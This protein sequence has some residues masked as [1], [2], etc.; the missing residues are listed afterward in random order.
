MKKTYLLLLLFVAFFAKAQNDQKKQI[1]LTSHNKESVR[2]FGVVRCLSTEADSL[3]RIQNPSRG[4]INE[5][6]DW[7]APKIEQYKR[8]VANGT[9]NRATI[10]TI[11]V[12]VHVIHN[13]D[14]VGTGENINDNQV[15]SQIRVLNEDFRRMLGTPGYN[16]NP[17]G[18][19]IEIEFCMAQTDPFGAA[20][21]GINRVNTGVA[22]YN[23]MAATDAMKTTTIWDPTQYLNMW[24][25]RFGGAMAGTLGYAQFPANSVLG[26][27]TASGGAANTDGVVSSFD[28]FGSQAYAAGTYNPTYNLGRTMT[29]EVGH[30]VGL[31]HIWGD[32]NC[33]VDDF[34]ADTPGSDAPNFGCPN[35]NSCVDPAPDPRDMVENYMDY[36]DDACMNI[37]TE[38]Q[39][40]R[41]RTVFTVSPRR[42]ELASST[43]CQPPSPI[44]GFNTDE[45]IINEATDCGYQD[46]VLSLGIALAPSADATVTFTTSGTATGSG[47]DF[48]IFPASVIFPAGSTPTRN[49]TVRIYNDGQ[50][51]STENIL[52]GMNIATSGNAVITSGTLKD[53]L[54]TINDDDFA[55]SPSVTVDIMNADFNTGANGFT[56]TGNAGSDFFRLG[57]AVTASSAF[58]TIQ[59]TNATQ[60]AF[61]NDDTC[62]CNKNNDMLIS[63]VF[64]LA[65]L[66]N[67]TLTFDHAFSA[68]VLAEVG[69]VRIST[70]GGATW[71]TIQT[72]TNTSTALGGGAISTPWVNGNTINLAAY[73]G[74]TNLRLA[75][76]YRDGGGWNY[77]MAIDN[78]RV[79]SSTVAVIQEAVNSANK[80]NVQLRNNETVHWFDPA[81]NNVMG[82][83][84][85]ASTFD[86]GCTTVEVDRSQVSLGAAT[87]PFIDTNVANE[88]LAKTF[89]I[90]PTN[91]SSTGNYTV[92]FYYTNAE[93]L[94]WETATGKSR[95]ELHVI[96]VI[97]NPVNLV[98]DI[99][100]SG[101][102]IEEIPATIVAF[103]SDVIF[104]ATF[105]TNLA[106]G[107]ALGPKSTIN[108]GDIVSTWNGSTWSNGS[109][110]KQIAIVINGDYDTALNGSFECCSLVVNSGF[111]F[112]IQ[113][114][115]YV[116]VVNELTNN[117]T[118]SIF[119]NGSLIQENDLAINTGTISYERIASVRLQDY[120]YWSSPIS[121]FDV[122][123]ISPLT[124]SAFYWTWNSTALNSNSGQ[125]N[126]VNASSIMDPGV[127]YIVRAP[128]GFSNTVNQN[129]VVNFNNGVP[130]NG[131][132]SPVISRGDNLNSGAVSSSGI[133]LTD[134][135]D[136]WNLIGNPYPSSI[137]VNA[138]LNANSEIDGFVRVWSHSTLPTALN[139]SSFYNNF[140]SNYSASD[141]ITINGAGSTSGPGTLS[142]IGGGQSFFVLMNS[143]S[144]ANSTVTFNN[145]MRDKT[146]SN[147]QFYRTSNIENDFENHRIWLDLVSTTETSRTL[148]SYNDRAT[149]GRDRLYDALTNYRNN[150]NIYSLLEN[151]PMV[152]QGKALPFSEED[153]VKIGVKVPS[154]GQYSI[155]I[156]ALDGLFANQNIF[157]KDNVNNVVHDLK[158]SPYSFTAVAGILNNR[159]EI[160]YK[161][162]VLSAED[163]TS[164][165]LTIYV[166]SKII[167]VVS[168]TEDIEEINVFDVLGR[169]LYE[170][171]SINNKTFSIPL[172]NT[173]NQ[174][175]I[176]KVKFKNGQ[177]YTQKIIL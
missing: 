70:N 126:W 130:N 117:G 118:F 167:N 19:D 150:Q 26:G 120:V 10:L 96:K 153:V 109:P 13:G 160:I 24:S 163:F 139:S 165:N 177:V 140:N 173:N 151:N 111:N 52:I 116:L 51:E 90:N 7:L 27:L 32:G 138:F 49:V 53:H 47:L 74:Q 59:N 66:S 80:D 22:S 30:W 135:D 93:V 20:T 146:F 142:V 44:I 127:G 58:W 62:N 141:Y 46:V 105:S 152:I 100:F 78:V 76:R 64:S 134:T 121:G 4:T 42:M 169:K 149:N 108:C 34:C 99:N 38:D 175:L 159:F 83:I 69:E 162:T 157:I 61:S 132:Y 115:N 143:G 9:L 75:F 91:D 23:S 5:F 79:F 35:T 55:P 128:N 102:N 65:G 8:Q 104:Q 54:I 148:I 28:A 101:F 133:T 88:I 31:R 41:I 84:Q 3:S 40:S 106:G 72:L 6:E 123:D 95:T 17:I 12:V 155:A 110:N 94:A 36:T 77:G 89:Y 67:A 43:K 82:T 1:K 98:N 124:P 119:N 92:S 166:E 171:I 107:Y 145:S 154:N 33:T 97:D 14:A 48:D 144:A 81:T 164:N 103:G 85:N 122:N 29:H 21:N 11:P 147:S 176:L 158:S 87:G 50:V 39:K 174:T 25:V 112:D 15:L 125:G 170:N 16:T 18:A 113:A 131:V 56:S 129:W 137:G 60:F 172:L 71:T 57:T 37:F 161:P 86:Y 68:G 45:T 63:P 73:L 168:S 114:D 136:N 156:G 2:R